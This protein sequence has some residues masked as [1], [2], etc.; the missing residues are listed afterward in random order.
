MQPNSTN[1]QSNRL[2]FKPRPKKLISAL[3]IIALILTGAY[4]LY[5]Q[6]HNPQAYKYKKIDT[7]YSLKDPA[8]SSSLS[9]SRPHELAQFSSTNSQ[10]EFQHLIGSNDGKNFA[11]YISAGASSS[12]NALTD[13][14]LTNLNKTLS[15]TSG[16]YYQIATSS[17]E[18]FVTD[19]VPLGSD[20]SFGNAKRFSN[21]N[22]KSNAW[23][24]DLNIKY[25]SKN[26]EGTSIYMAGKNT[27]Y[28]FMLLTPDYNWQSNQ[29]VWQ[30]VIDSIKINQ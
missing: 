8:S 22:I 19:R 14:D 29:K 9:F 27:Y 7:A 21:P 6:L 10:V 17:L 12:A 30:Q 5:R 26:T 18:T 2:W 23:Q 1:L 15:D 3:V 16:V 24:L 11:A 28:F 4:G 25:K 13:T 20:I